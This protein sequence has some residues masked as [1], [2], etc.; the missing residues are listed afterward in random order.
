MEYEVL[1]W[2]K[3]KGDEPTLYRP[4]EEIHDVVDT[5]EKATVFA[6]DLIRILQDYKPYR[7]E[8]IEKRKVRSKEI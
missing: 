5:L 7:Y 8:I 1:V 4:F 3:F 2:T 6:E